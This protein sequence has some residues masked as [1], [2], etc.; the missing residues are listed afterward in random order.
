MLLALFVLSRT[1]YRGPVVQKI[2]GTAR[3]LAYGMV[4]A[5]GLGLYTAHNA[6]AEFR[7]QGLQVGQD[8][9]ELTDLLGE[10]DEIR[11]NNQSIYMSTAESDE[12]IGQVLDRFQA[13]CDA[14]PGAMKDLVKDVVEKKAVIKDL[15]KKDTKTLTTQREESDNSGTVI[16]MAGA[17]GGKVGW[18]DAITAFTQTGDLANIGNLR[19]VYAQKNPK[20]G[21]TSIRTIWTEG[22]FNF[23]SVMPKDQV[24]DAPGSDANNVPRP[25]HTRRVFTAEAANNQYAARYYLTD[26]AAKDV[27]AAYDAKMDKLGWEMVTTD[28]V[29]NSDTDTTHWYMNYKTGEQMVFQAAHDDHSNKTMAIV[30]TVGKLEKPDTAH[31]ATSLQ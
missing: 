21:T 7:E 3:V 16:C 14:H 12:P 19:Y 28:L 13:N 30:A 20:K 22:H 8:L 25:D 1:K 31:S 4:V 11:I 29:P 9:Q 10:T 27:L 24:G 15:D 26:D 17:D 23:Y 6:A 5:G 2:F 18:K